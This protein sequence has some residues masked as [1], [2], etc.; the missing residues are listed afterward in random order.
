MPKA[1][2]SSA[3]SR[4][5]KPPAVFE[6]DGNSQRLQAVLDT[7]QD[8]IVSINAAGI[9]KWANR[10]TE[11]VFGW[12]PAE[13]TGKN[14]A[15]LITGVDA[16]THNGHITRYLLTGKSDIIG[17]RRQ[18][19]AQHRDGH[20]LTIELAV[21]EAL[22]EGARVFVAV[23]RDLTNLL[24]QRSELAVIA[25]EI[26][27][28]LNVSP[29]GIALFDR[30]G[31]LRHVNRVFKDLMDCHQ[32]P[33]GCSI[34]NLD[35]RV[36]EMA[37]GQ[38]VYRPIMELLP[39]G[40]D[41]L[42]LEHPRHL[43]LRRTVKSLTG[44][45][46]VVFVHD[47]TE[48]YDVDRMKT[49]FLSSAAHELRTP[50]ASIHGFS[51]LMLKREFDAA[52]RQEMLDTIHRQSSAMVS[53]VNELLDL[54][55]IEARAGKDFRIRP[56]ELPSMMRSV[57]AEFEAQR[58]ISLN[59]APD[60]PKVWADTEKLRQVIVNLLSNAVKYSPPGSPVEMRVN[61]GTENYIEILV[62]DRGIGMTPEQIERVFDR[63]YRVDP[64]GPVTGSGLGMALVKEIVNIHQGLIAVFPRP[65]G[66][67]RVRVSLRI[68]GD[69]AAIR[70]AENKIIDKY[71]K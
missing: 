71:E 12:A 39:S 26:E 56:C 2:A 61:A 27:A 20:T 65:G 42:I 13:L 57:C 55:R 66:G 51:E 21:T 32:V 10:S 30:D 36:A 4:R 35:Q 22:V 50:M 62:E 23:A 6:A 16:E 14:I 19:Q 45:G 28:V 18:V 3:T 70:M 54:A 17:K 34:G 67:L 68:A 8:A 40:R 9:V 31:G 33:M 60:L 11:T 41:I 5:R 48:T 58:H 47:I 52:T 15:V 63:F 46:L 25:S 37:T 1:P 69:Q 64:N 59:I 29:S 49:E 44:G 24:K 43:V 7:V 53:L 38:G